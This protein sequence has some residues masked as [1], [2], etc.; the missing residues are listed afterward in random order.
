MP[1]Q[2]FDEV[3][4]LLAEVAAAEEDNVLAV[5]GV[6]SQSILAG[7][8]AYIYGAGHA[9]IL[10]MEMFFRAG[11]L[12]TV[13]PILG[14][15]TLL[16]QAPISH[17]SR[18]ERLP[19][20]GALLAQKVK[21][22]PGDVVFV[23]SVSGRNPAGI[24]VA[25][26]AKAAGAATVAITSV[27]YSKSVTSRHPGGQRLFEV[28]DYVLDN[29]GVPGDALCQ[30]EGMDARVAPSSTVIGAALVNAV[31]AE[32]VRLLLAKGVKAPPVYYSANL[33]GGDERNRAL[34]AEYAD[35]IHYEL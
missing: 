17:T 29:H 1:L 4:K 14:A 22:A 7:R 5:A 13:N 23:H 21:I 11:G 6:L 15:E 16:D 18:M 9:S 34:F 31:V 25:L 30:M 19:G 33:D 27:A 32:T 26:A 3:Q 24:E 8:A 20:Y 35:A 10:T 28:C 12:M 2:Y